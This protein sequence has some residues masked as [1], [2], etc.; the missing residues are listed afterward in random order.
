[1]LVPGVYAG[2]TMVHTFVSSMSASLD[3][4]AMAKIEVNLSDIPEGKSAVFKWR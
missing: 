3:V 2:K 4:L 1:M